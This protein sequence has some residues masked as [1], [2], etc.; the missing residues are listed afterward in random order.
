MTQ[1]ARLAGLAPLLG[2][3][4]TT[5]KHPQ[6][7]GRT[8]RGHVSFELIEGG[9]FVRVRSTSV[10]REIPS[11]VAILGTD[12][13]K[14]EGTMLYFD[15]RGVSRHYSFQIRD[16]Q[17]AW[18][19]DDPGFRQR[20]TVTVD[21]GGQRLSGKGEMSRDGAPWEGDLELEYEREGKP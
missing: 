1:N 16:G 18:W 9:S 20:F 19:R 7:P 14:G 10:D 5:G 2:E 4:T 11:G 3:W 17:L 15:Q 8:L 12:D 6:L 13:G 21:P